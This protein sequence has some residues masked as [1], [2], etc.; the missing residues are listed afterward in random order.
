MEFDP[1]GSIFGPLLFLIYIT[2]YS[3]LSDKTIT[4]D[5]RVFI[6]DNKI[7]EVEIVMNSDIKRLYFIWPNFL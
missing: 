7:H 6:Q 1:R 5:T 2:G 3:S 4:D